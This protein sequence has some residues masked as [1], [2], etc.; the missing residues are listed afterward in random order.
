MRTHGRATNPGLYAQHVTGGGG[1]LAVTAH[2]VDV[3][4]R[5]VATLANGGEFG[6]GPHA[7]AWDGR[8]GTRVP[9]SSGVYFVSVRA[10]DE[11]AVR[12]VLISH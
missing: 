11:H 6:A 9:V 4:G 10:G 5:V 1:A 2:V 12:K 3:G 7:L 8:D